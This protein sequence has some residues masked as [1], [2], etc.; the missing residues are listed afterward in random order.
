MC[1]IRTYQLK[2][3]EQVKKI[4]LNTGADMPS[5]GEAFDDA[6]LQSFCYYYIEQE[7]ENCFVAADER[8]D[9][10]GYVICAADF[11][12][13]EQRFNELYLSV[14]ANDIAKI[15]G[16]TTIDILRPFSKEY[17][18]HLHI[19][20]SPDYQKKGLGK[21]LIDALIEHLKSR[22]V[23]GLL[24][25]VS[26]DNESGIGFYKKYGFTELKR[27]DVEVVMCIRVYD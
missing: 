25:N 15:I 10:V 14:T 11:D 1:T 9:A 3:R 23:R 21:K 7:P 18:A 13:W 5:K 22:G 8:D 4:C 2:D 27:G 24:L 12:T 6:M 17:P 20:I 19:D 26:A 16:R